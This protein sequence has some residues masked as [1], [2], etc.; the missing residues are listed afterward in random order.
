MGVHGIEN[1]G[2]KRL[3]IKIAFIKQKRIIVNIFLLY[4][5]NIGY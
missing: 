2:F 3:L 1:P 4:K 5:N